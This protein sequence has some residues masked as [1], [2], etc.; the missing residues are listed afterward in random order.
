MDNI[1]KHFFKL[2]T[3]LLFTNVA[4]AQDLCVQIANNDQLGSVNNNVSFSFS[5][6]SLLE[7][8]SDALDLA[9]F[10]Q[11]NNGTLSFDETTKMFT[12]TPAAGFAGPVNFNYTLKRAQETRLGPPLIINGEEH[13]YEPL[14]FDYRATWEDAMAQAASKSYNGS[15]GYLA[16]ITSAAENEF[17]Q[18]I[19]SKIT[20]RNPY[21]WL[22][23]NDKAEEGVWRW[24]TGPEAGMLFNYNNWAKDEPNDKRGEDYLAISTDGKWNDV[25]NEGPSPY[26]PYTYLVEYGSS[27]NCNAGLTASVSFLLNPTVPNE[28]NGCNL[29]LT[30]TTMQAEPWWPMWGVMNGAGSIDLTVTG[31]TAPYTYKWN[32]GVTT[33]DISAA[34]PG[35]YT[36]M[37]TDA[38]GC[39]AM[40]SVYVGHKNN[41]LI[42]T[43]SHI[44]ATMG[45]GMDGSVDLSVIGGTGPYT[46]V[47]S[48]GATTEDLTMVAAGTYSVTVMDA[49]GKQGMTSVMVGERGM[50]LTLSIVHQDVMKVGGYGS[51]D[52]SIMGGVAPYSIL[53]N[54]GSRNE[55]LPQ[56]T[57]GMYMVTVTDAVGATATASVHVAGFGIPAIA[58]RKGEPGRE[59]SLNPVKEVGLAAYPN[60]TTDRATISF[61][62]A[63]TGNYTLDLFDI[64]GAKVKNI[65]SGKGQVDQQLS[66]ELNVPSQTKGVYLIRLVSDK[67]VI[68]KRILFKQ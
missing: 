16:T 58:G 20:L 49:M 36:V 42:L 19:V 11:P 25:S 8:D 34:S 51:I 12:Y 53:W 17:I 21:V 45:G 24:A 15:S 22:G 43:S 48:N 27:E 26:F 32:A 7:N 56:V 33:Q 57:P 10:T 30:T 28:G 59:I 64:R 18:E 5:L 66:V 63:E 13:Y 50:P 2:L 40:T 61:N 68:T 65:A 1:F 9:S 29:A 54:A 41:P 23:A 6:E 55:D 31:G 37:V 44:D 67:Q 14:E 52:L 35:L 62:L 46:F 60:P 47:W 4:V 39:S 38:A 3:F